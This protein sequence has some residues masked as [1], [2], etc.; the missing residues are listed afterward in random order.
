MSSGW[1]G[2]SGHRY[3]FELL[4]RIPQAWPGTDDVERR[5][6][7]ARVLARRGHELPRP[8][9]SDRRRQLGLE[10]DHV[11]RRKHSRDDRVRALEEVVHDLDLLRPGTEARERLHETL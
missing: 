11:S 3:W 1:S 7:R 5:A 10:S 9:A 6:A 4:R 8:D 2:R